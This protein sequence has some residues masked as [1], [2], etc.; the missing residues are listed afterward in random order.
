MQINSK[1]VGY[2]LIIIAIS[3]AIITYFFTTKI[4]DSYMQACSNTCSADP[5]MNYC[6]HEHAWPIE[7]FIASFF[8]LAILALAIL[9]I[10]LDKFS[11][12]GKINEKEIRFKEAYKLA[13][14]D[15]RKILELLKENSWIM[16]QSEIVERSG[17]SKVKVTR[18]LDKL[19][20]RGY[21][22]RKRRG[23]TNV[24]IFK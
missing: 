13:N 11:E 19:E 21:V 2:I 9:L 22:E 15:E 6:P 4:Q 16:F 20:A 24:V 12:G 5:E 17:F 8:I 3:L 23:M 1:L 7:T 14:K 10:F 18:L